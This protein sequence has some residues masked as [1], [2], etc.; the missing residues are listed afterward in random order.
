MKALIKTFLKPLKKF[1]ARMKIEIIIENRE[2]GHQSITAFSNY[3]FATFVISFIFFV[4]TP[5]D[6]MFVFLLFCPDVPFE[7]QF[8]LHSFF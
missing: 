5:C 6:S 7:E 8:S 1:P 2:K 4:I 3:F